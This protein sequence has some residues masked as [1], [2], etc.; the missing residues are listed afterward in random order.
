MIGPAIEYIGHLL[1]W[2]KQQDFT[3]SKMLEMPCYHPAI[4]EGVRTVLRKLN[5]NFKWASHL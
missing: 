1:A 2:T 3:V 4:E 5:K